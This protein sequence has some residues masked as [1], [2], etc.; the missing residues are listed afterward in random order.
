MLSPLFLRFFPELS[1]ADGVSFS[2]LSMSAGRAGAGARDF[3]AP[4]DLLPVGPD[5]LE[6]IILEDIYAL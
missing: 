3:A 2:R 4:G 1:L 5:V 6:R